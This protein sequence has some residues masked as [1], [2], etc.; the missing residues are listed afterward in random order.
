MG[1]DI[2]DAC[3]IPVEEQQEQE[4]ECLGNAEDRRYLSQSHHILPPQPLAEKPSEHIDNGSFAEIVMNMTLYD[5]PR[6]GWTA[7]GGISDVL[8]P[9]EVRYLILRR[10]LILLVQFWNLAFDRSRNF[11]ASIC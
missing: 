3:P 10:S 11:S 8:S 2:D 5:P 7:V 6:W 4:L 1:N 9:H